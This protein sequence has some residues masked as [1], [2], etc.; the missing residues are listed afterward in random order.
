MAMI[1]M[2]QIEA[3]EDA[4][5]LLQNPK[6]LRQQAKENGYLFF[7]R[8]LD[9]AR[10]LEAR[11]QILGVCRDHGWLADGFRTDSGHCKSRY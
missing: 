10:V 3:P 9:P 5:A 2:K 4:T 6:K 8:L 11:R 7:R 1:D